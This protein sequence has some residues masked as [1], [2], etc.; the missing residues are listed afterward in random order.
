MSEFNHD[1]HVT[2]DRNTARALLSQVFAWMA[3]AISVSGL[4]AWFAS[5]NPQILSMPM[6][7]MLFFVQIGIVLL[8]GR[9]LAG[10]SYGSVKALF[11]VYAIVSGLS[12]S[13]IFLLYSITSII[14]IFFA[15]AGM[16]AIMAMYG[17]FTNADLSSWGSLLS[18]AVWGILI[19]LL[20]NVFVGNTFFDMVISAIGV[21][22]FA[23]L[24]AYDV[25]NIKRLGL[26]LIE[27][28]EVWQKVTII[29]ALT[30]YLD[31]INIFLFMLQLFGERRR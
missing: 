19:S 9:N 17:W 2:G 3:I 15:T 11:L 23:A 8:L 1:Y 30:L 6:F 27:R 25:Q 5:S 28:D 20:I 14:Q 12:L 18:M 16:F 24:T 21:I 26:A 4:S 29:C 31:F 7:I 13:I 10:L 22:V